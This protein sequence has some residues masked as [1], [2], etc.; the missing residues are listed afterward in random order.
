MHK[1]ICS[2]WKHSSPQLTWL[3]TEEQCSALSVMC[4]LLPYVLILPSL[5]PSL[6]T[7]SLPLFLPPSL[8]LSL[9]HLPPSL[10]FSPSLSLSLPLSLSLSLS[11]SLRQRDCAS[12]H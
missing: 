10:S 5:S 8:S 2:T 11:L 4:F 3:G 1:L 7:L 9:S 12:S 6:H